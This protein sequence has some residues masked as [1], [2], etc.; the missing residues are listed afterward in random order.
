MDDAQHILPHV[1]RDL[2]RMLESLWMQYEFAVYD[3]DDFANEF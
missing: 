1:V 2:D 3:V